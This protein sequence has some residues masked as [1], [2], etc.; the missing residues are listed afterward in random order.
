MSPYI[1]ADVGHASDFVQPG[2]P[3]SQGISGVGA[4]SHSTPY[5]PLIVYA[6]CVLNVPSPLSTSESGMS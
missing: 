1:S 3:S 4:A 6:G 2:W 5:W